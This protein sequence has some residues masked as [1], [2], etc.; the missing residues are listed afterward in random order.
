ME[1]RVRVVHKVLSSIILLVV[2]G[3]GLVCISTLV[4]R[5]EKVVLL[6]SSV[7]LF[8]VF[9][10]AAWVWNCSALPRP[11]RLGVAGY[12]LLG[13]IPFVLIVARLCGL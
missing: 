3:C 10:Y 8:G 12:A 5:V 6:S 1:R 4:P 11:Y 13:A 9:A 2:I 7:A